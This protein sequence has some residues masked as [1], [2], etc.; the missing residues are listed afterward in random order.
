MTYFSAWSFKVPRKMSIP[1][2]IILPGG[3]KRIPRNWREHRGLSTCRCHR[4]KKRPVPWLGMEEGKRDQTVRRPRRLEKKRKRRRRVVLKS[5]SPRFEFIKCQKFVRNH[6][7]STRN[8][9]KNMLTCDMCAQY[10]QRHRRPVFF[11]SR[12]LLTE[13]RGTWQCGPQRQVSAK[14]GPT[15]P[16][17]K[18]GFP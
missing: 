16:I 9:Q 18:P 13:H 10:S 1:C 8:M 5:F 3:E 17:Q 7:S 2:S 4:S 6:W 12:L 11:S 14:R 15:W